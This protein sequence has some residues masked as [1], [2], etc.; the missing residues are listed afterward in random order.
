MP[1]YSP[2][3]GYRASNGGIVFKREKSL[4]GQSFEVPCGKCIGCRLDY[5]RDWAVRCKHEA[6]MNEKN[7]FITLTYNN[8]NLPENGTLVKKDFQDFMKRLRK[9]TDNKIKYFHCG[10][11]GEKTKRP[12]YHA[13]IFNYEMED[14]IPWVNRNG[15]QTYISEDLTRIWS[16]GITEIGQVTWKSA[17]YCA[18]YITK[19]VYGEEAEKHY[20]SEIQIN[21]KTGEM[22]V[23]KTLQPEYTTCSNRGGGIGRSWYEKYKSDIWN[24][25]CVTIIDGERPFKC[26]VPRYY[27]EI[28]KKEQP[29]KYEKFK[30]KQLEFAKQNRDNNTSHML[31]MREKY[32]QKRAKKLVRKIEE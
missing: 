19:K 15:N 2:L 31:K 21:K 16:K 9:T 26:S 30:S 28:L 8:E 13:L 17:A 5:S 29:E 1:C 24:N 22:T 20:A 3:K 14:K 11:Y 12:H 32:A 23:I 25:G 6:R 18:R 4:N 27:T 7:M 10:E